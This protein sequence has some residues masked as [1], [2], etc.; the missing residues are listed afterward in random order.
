MGNR[1][2]QRWAYLRRWAPLWLGVLLIVLAIV[3]GATTCA[4]IEATRPRCVPSIRQVPVVWSG[5]SANPVPLPT[6]ES[7]VRRGPRGSR[8]VGAI[9]AGPGLL[10]TALRGRE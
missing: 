3:G 2:G 1:I 8:S 5:M 7:G 9:A 6:T 10:P 4:I